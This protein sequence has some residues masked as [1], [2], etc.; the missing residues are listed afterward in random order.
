MT[1]HLLYTE[2]DVELVRAAVVKALSK[3]GEL[4]LG[5]TVLDDLAAA[6]RLMPPGGIGRTEWLVIGKRRQKDLCIDEE[7]ARIVAKLVGGRIKTR[8]VMAWPGG[9]VYASG[10]TDVPK[11][12]GG[13]PVSP[14]AAYI[15]DERDGEFIPAK[16]RS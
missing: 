7:E 15:V 11:H 6:G 14:G 9:A 2:E 3:P 13:G 10:W 5:R 12:A 8:Q 1:G 4:S 16:E